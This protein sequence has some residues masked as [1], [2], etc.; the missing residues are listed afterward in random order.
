MKILMLWLLAALTVTSSVAAPPQTPAKPPR[1]TISRATTYLT[2]P[3][4]PDGYVDYLE[5]LDRQSRQGVTPEINAVVLVIQALGLGDIRDACRPEFLRR[6]GTS[7][8]DRDDWFIPWRTYSKPFTQD[9][10]T[11][12][13]LQQQ[14]D[15]ALNRPWKSTEF[16]LLGEWLRRNERSLRL[17]VAASR[18]LRWYQPLVDDSER[19]SL[20]G[21][22]RN[23]MPPSDLRRAIDALVI[24]AMLEVGHGRIDD[25]WETLI[26]CR[27]LGRLTASGCTLVHCLT[28][29]AID[30]RTSHAMAA[31]AHHERLAAPQMLSYAKQ[32]GVRSKFVD[33]IEVVNDRERLVFLALVDSVARCEESD[34]RFLFLLSEE[35]VLGTLRRVLGPDGIDWDETRRIG[36]QWTDRAVAALR[37]PNYQMAATS[38]HR[39]INEEFSRSSFEKH[40]WGLAFYWLLSPSDGRRALGR[41]LGR[42]WV[43]MFG[44]PIPVLL[45]SEQTRATQSVQCEVAFALAAYRA[46]HGE[47]P[48]RLE[49]LRPKYVSTLPT[50][51]F[52]DQPFHY[53]RQGTGYRLWSV[54]PNGRD[55]HGQGPLDGHGDDVTMILP[56]PAPSSDTHARHD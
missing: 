54:G 49:H 45:T 10:P 7:E 24:R 55:D 27:R 12:R 17:L 36:N 32:V 50:D 40:D 19:P 44:G 33:L 1:V 48:V 42:A 31:L 35:P 3:L 56:R 20:I 46:D 37:L 22:F 6:L 43:Q 28:G 14:H 15:E 2:E 9:E 34:V 39:A 29:I 47:Y 13:L 41:A 23:G 25:A 4:R 21:A 30:R 5:A 16:P 52:V 26:A 38:L 11:K 51:P 53:E 18:R 8:T